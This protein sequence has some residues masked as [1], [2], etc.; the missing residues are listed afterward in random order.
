MRCWLFA[1]AAGIAVVGFWP[2]L[3]KLTV[4]PLC[5]L[6][7]ILPLIFA[8]SICRM[9]SGLGFGTGWGV[10][11]AVL[12]MQTVLPAQWQRHD[13]VVAGYISSLPSYRTLSAEQGRRVRFDF[14]VTEVE[15]ID[16]APGPLP[17]V[18]RIRLSWYQIGDRKLISGQYWRFTVRLKK[19]RSFHNPGSSDYAAQLLAKKIGAIGYIRDNPPAQLL[20]GLA[21]QAS[22]HRLRA[23][24]GEY[25]LNHFEYGPL[26]SALVI[27]DRSA[28]PK[29]QRELLSDTGT[30]HLLAISGLHIGFVALLFFLAGIRLCSW[31]LLPLKFLPAPCYGAAAAIF[32][33]M[34]YA[35][36]AGFSLP[37]RRALIMVTVA[38]SAVLLRRKLSYSVGFCIALLG[39]LVLE[40]LAAHTAGFWLSFT[41]VAALLIEFGRHDESSASA[42]VKRLERL[43]RAQAA[44]SLA[45][46][47]PLGIYL[48]AVP[49]MSPVANLF[50]IPW[51]SL[52]VVPLALGGTVLSV[53]SDRFA[54]YLLLVADWG[55]D[56]LFQMLIL[57][58][59][60]SKL[61]VWHPPQWPAWA[62]LGGAAGVLGALYFRDWRLRLAAVALLLPLIFVSVSRQQFLTLTVLDVGQGLAAVVQTE[63][64]SLVYDAGP[65]LGKS[66]TGRLVVLPALRSH[67]IDV[68]DK[69][70]ISHFDI[71]H[72]GG[73]PSILEEMDVPEVIYGDRWQHTDQESQCHQRR[74]VPCRAG[75]SWL[76]DD[77]QFELIHPLSPL[78][79]NENNNSCVL[80][81]T[82]AGHSFLLPGDIGVAAEVGLL[83]RG[84]ESIAPL[85]VLLAPHHGSNTSSSEDFVARLT[86]R[87]VVFSAGYLNHFRHAADAVRQRYHKY[88]TIML[89]TAADGAVSFVL[90]RSG[91]LSLPHRYRSQH[92]RYWQ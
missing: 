86:P 88:N 18:K 50:A 40:P 38:M 13:F 34:G 66:D 67:G 74:C 9:L 70:I 46:I 87:Y 36:L 60:Y 4:L 24:L 37:T 43:I 31:S 22:H 51:V 25:L 23:Q 1:A 72:V 83:E 71:D 12:L 26:L 32:G 3:P 20:P 90:Q 2:E 39:V 10:I 64:H 78:S 76:W 84:L 65:R 27:G 47:V 82:A 61:P 15:S 59:Y 7:L 57:L 73:V 85:S 11:S 62:V 77:V 52:V 41:A 89:T 54:Q 80:L 16:D 17:A 68:P 5:A 44:V 33:A 29:R 45:L 30:A 69:V 63:S 75:M 58:E 35:A 79:S 48:H 19:P 91:V 8:H 49:V 6:L 42:L 92:K 53:F 14:T 55:I 28:L 21:W 56:F 81:I